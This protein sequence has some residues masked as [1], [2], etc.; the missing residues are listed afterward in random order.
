GDRADGVVFDVRRDVHHEARA[1]RRIVHIAEITRAHAAGVDQIA[2]P[3]LMIH[4]QPD[5]NVVVEWKIRDSLSALHVEVAERAVH[6]AAEFAGWFL[7]Y[8]Q[9]G[10]AGRVAAKQGALRTLQHLHILEVEERSR[11]R[12]VSGGKAV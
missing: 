4:T 3:R 2:F 12:A 9:N 5:A 7:R 6:V 8:E 10:A 11:S 1:R